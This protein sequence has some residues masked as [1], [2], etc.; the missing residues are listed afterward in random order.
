M[1]RGAIGEQITVRPRNNV[2]TA[3]AGITVVIQIL[4][5]IVLMMRA[6]SVGG[7]L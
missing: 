1:S 2:Y 6:G 7:L 4:G 3:L 5:L